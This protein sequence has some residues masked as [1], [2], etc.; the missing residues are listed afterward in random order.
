MNTK[1][2]AAKCTDPL[3]CCDL[4]KAGL[5]GLGCNVTTEFVSSAVLPTSSS[6]W[7]MHA[8]RSQGC[9]RMSEPV[10]LVYGQV[11]DNMY[12]RVHDQCVTSEVFG[13][14]RCDCKEQFDHAKAMMAAKG[15]GIVI[16]MPQEGRGIG[17]ANKVHAYNLQDQGADTVDANRVLGFEDDYRSYE[18]VLHIL[19]HFNISRIQLCTNN[20]RKIQ[21]LTELGI[22]VTARV[23]VLIPGQKHN[24]AYLDAKAHRMDHM[25]ELSPNDS[26]MAASTT[27]VKKASDLMPTIHI[28]VG[29][30]LAMVVYM[31]VNSI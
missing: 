20:P 13:S 2:E 29:S 12:V 18:P 31:L 28:M 5:T 15:N 7:R 30:V 17:L 21:L 6:E 16:Y 1:L 26:T 8:F 24:Q 3:N 14:L 4:D 9:R 25:L 10:A 19:R 23:P 11:E 22:E 27:D